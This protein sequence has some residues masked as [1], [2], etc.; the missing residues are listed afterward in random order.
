MFFFR[1]FLFFAIII[2]VLTVL[3]RAI[4]G[5]IIA[6]FKNRFNSQQKDGQKVYMDNSVKK[7]KII[8][9]SEGNYIDFE[10]IKE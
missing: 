6:P 5:I 7:E 10:E 1:F 9:K 8:K 2:F 4:S 3:V